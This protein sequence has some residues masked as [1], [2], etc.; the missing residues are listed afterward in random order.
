MNTNEVN[1]MLTFDPIS[2]AEEVLGGSYKEDKSVLAMGFLLNMTHGEKKIRVLESLDDTTFSNKLPRYL[3]I[4]GELGFTPIITLPF[5][6]TGYGEGPVQEK[7]FVFLHRKLGILLSFDTFGGGS[8]NSSKFVYCWKATPREDL[9]GVLSSGGQE[10]ESGLPWPKEGEPEA[11]DVYYAGSHDGREAIRH[12]ITQL[13][14]KGTFLNPWPVKKPFMWL[15]HYMDTKD[16]DYNHKAITAER[17]SMFP[18]WAR[19]IIGM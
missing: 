14:S 5:T 11:E 4:V 12:H 10:R 19:D 2:H 18:K 8:V 7:F 16:K 3:R 9:T 13:E 15:L 1:E 6:G 17:I